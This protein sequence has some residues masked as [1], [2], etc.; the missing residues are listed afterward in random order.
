ML[1]KKRLL[2]GI[3]PTGDLTLGNYLGIIKPLVIFQKKYFKEY[4]FYIFI[5]DLHALT[6]FQDPILLKKRIESIAFLYLASGLDIQNFFL[7]AQS[8]IYQNTYLNYILECNTYLGELKRMNQ[9]KDYQKKN[10]SKNIRTSFLTYP[11]LMASDILLYD[12]DIVP[13]GKDQKQHLELT[14]N[15]A[16]RFNQLYG[17]TFIVPE[18]IKLGHTIK[19][20]VDPTKKMSKSQTI[21]IEYSEDRGCIFIL[22]KLENIKKKIMRSK[23]DS[24]NKI[25]YDP[26]NK[27][28]ISNLIVIYS[29]FKEWSIKKTENYFFNSSYVFLKE[30]V[31]ELVLKKISDLQKKFFILKKNIILKDILEK[32]A[33]K[34][35]I[36]AEEKIKEIKLKIGLK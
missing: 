12:I 10:F 4:E 29:C 35:R 32:N 14:R 30:K 9:F 23:T 6:S 25:K 20:L 31:S 8:D 7:F 28:G 15:L 16:I 19:S 13:V 18:F 36:I 5:A 33:K 21:D 1:R 2:T 34:V 22:E 17:K 27:P 11:I 26:D 3:K 24:E